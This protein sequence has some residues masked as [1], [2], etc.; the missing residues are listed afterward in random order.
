LNISG[1][2]QHTRVFAVEPSEELAPIQPEEI[3]ILT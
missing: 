3:E 2:R 1:I